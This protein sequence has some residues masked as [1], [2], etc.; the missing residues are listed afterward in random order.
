MSLFVRLLTN[1]P[2]I[3]AAR[4]IVQ[5]FSAICPPPSKASKSVSEK[6]VADALSVLY[7]AAANVA[8]LHR[9]G[10]LRRAAFA[11]A[12]QSEL[13]RLGYPSELVGK[14][15]SALTIKALVRH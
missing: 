10:V 5:D 14:I 3:E 6:R 12:I 9:L 1:A 2:L 4:S 7:G 11:K 13:F 8:T 15:V